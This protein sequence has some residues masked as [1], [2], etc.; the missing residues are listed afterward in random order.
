MQILAEFTLSHPLTDEVYY[1]L[2]NINLT[3]IR[4]S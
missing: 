1:Q 4:S 2:A 3:S